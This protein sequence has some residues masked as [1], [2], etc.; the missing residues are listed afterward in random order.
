MTTIE[1]VL[2]RSDHCITSGTDDGLVMIDVESGHYFSLDSI[3]R[4]IWNRLEQPVLVG[5]LCEALEHAY[6]APLEVITA[7][8]LRLMMT[9]A[10]EGLVKVVA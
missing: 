2:V 6:A 10:D 7:D 3:G 8:V 9:M 4:D 1:T 5:D